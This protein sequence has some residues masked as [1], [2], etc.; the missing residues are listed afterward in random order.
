MLPEVGISSKKV[1][2]QHWVKGVHYAVCEPLGLF[3]LSWKFM[4]STVICGHELTML[5]ITTGPSHH[6]DLKR[7]LCE[8]EC[9]VIPSSKLNS[10]GK[11]RVPHL[12]RRRPKLPQWRSKAVV[13][14]QN[15]EKPRALSVNFH[16]ERNESKSGTKQTEAGSTTNK[17]HGDGEA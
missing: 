6:S 9:D 5:T 4:L 2:Y 10:G 7:E 17:R 11:W 8:L 15:R 3:L 13:F 14:G 12:L 16:M 1:G